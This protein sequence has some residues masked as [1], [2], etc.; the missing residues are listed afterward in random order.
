MHRALVLFLPLAGLLAP[1]VAAQGF[2]SRKL[3]CDAQPLTPHAGNGNT[4][5]DALLGVQYLGGLFYVTG[6]DAANGSGAHSIYVFDAACQRVRVFDQP[7]YTASSA[8][9]FRDGMSDGAGLGFGFEDGIGFLDGFGAPLASFGGVAIG[10]QPLSFPSYPAGL[11]Y[12]AL[13]FDPAAGSVF[14]GDFGSAIHEFELAT[15]NL[16][17]SWPNLA[18]ADEW[19]A[20]GFALD[21]LRTSVSEAALWVSGDAGERA[22]RLYRLPRNGAGSTALATSTRIVR[23]QPLSAVGGL[24]EVPLGTPLAPVASHWDLAA[25]DQGA[26]DV[27][28]TFRVHAYATCDA[29]QDAAL[30]ASAALSLATAQATRAKVETVRFYSGDWLYWD[31]A[32]PT[33]VPRLGAVWGNVK[34]AALDETADRLSTVLDPAFDLRVAWGGSAPPGF[35]PLYLGPNTTVGGP[36]SAFPIPAGNFKPGEGFRVQGFFFDPCNPAFPFHATNQV[37]FVSEAGFRPPVRV[38]AEGADS[39]DADP[40]RGFWRIENQD[41]LGRSIVSVTLDWTGSPNPAQSTMRFDTDQLGMG[42]VFEGGNGALS[43]CRGTYRNASDVATGLLYDASCTV[44]TTPCDPTAITGWIGTNAG[45]NLEDW[46]TLQF[47]FNAFGPDEVFEFDCDTD[48]GAGIRGR[49]MAGLRVI[50]VL[51]D[52]S[53]LSGVLAASGPQRAEVIL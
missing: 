40:A 7:A 29:T 11:V 28:S 1:D 39:F 47:R 46:R 33:G 24:S 27:V 19:S 22:I 15:G 5:D 14:V 42:D 23:D 34:V 16:L 36:P 35:L 43:G 13:A 26:S 8:W 48:G 52:N 6:R 9:G 50:V 51:S 38:V 20:F 10:S 49:D 12:R 31:F 53:V 44:P 41:R 17:H 25:L 30:V 4:V 21:P 2:G 45:P 37:R 3:R 18:G 32:D